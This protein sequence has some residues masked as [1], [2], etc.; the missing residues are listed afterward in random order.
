MAQLRLSFLGTF[1]VQLDERVITQ[2]ESDKVRALLVYLAEEHGKAHTRTALAGL[3]WPE[4]PES[5]ARN[6]LRQAFFKLRRAIGDQFFVATRRTIQW[7]VNGDFWLDTAVF[8]TDP[9]PHYGGHFLDQFFLKN[10]V[11]FEEWILIKREGYHRQAMTLLFDW[12]EQARLAGDLA[13]AIQLAGRQIELD[14][15]REEAHLQLMQILM[16]QGQR[17]EAIAQYKRCQRIL[18]DELGV[19][20]SATL[21]TFYQQLQRQ[22][23]RPWQSPLH[24]LPPQPTPFVGRRKEVEELATRLKTPNCRLVTI[25][26]A[27]GMGKTRLSVA[28]GEHC[29]AHFRDGV[30]FIPL[31]ALDW[32]G[33][34]VETAVHTLNI[35]LNGRDDPKEQL[36]QYLRHKNMLLIFDN[37]EHLLEGAELLQDIWQAAPEIR[38]LVTSRER[39]RFRSEWQFPLAGLPFPEGDAKAIADYDAVKLFVQSTRMTRPD[40]TLSVV[41]RPFIVQICQLM[42]GL[43]LGIELAAAWIENY[44]CREI[45]QQIQQSLDFVVSTWRDSPERHQSLR[46]VFHHSWQLLTIKEQRCLAQLGVLRGDFSL[47]AAQAVAQVDKAELGRLVDKSLLQSLKDNRYQFHETIRQ[48]ALEQL[49]EDTVVYDRYATFYLDLLQKH[50]QYLLTSTQKEAL[51]AIGLEIDHIRS[52]WQ[53]AVTQN[54]Q[55]AVQHATSPLAL[56]YE[57]RSWFREGEIVFREAIEQLAETAVVHILLL[58]HTTFLSRLGHNNEAKQQAHRALALIPSD[59]ISAE[60]SYAQAALGMI[61][62]NQGRFAQA[63]H[64]F[65]QSLHGYQQASDNNGLAKVAYSLGKICNMQGEFAEA[66]NFLQQGLEFVQGDSDPNLRAG[67]HNVLGITMAMSGSLSEARMHFSQSVTSYRETGYLYGLAYALLNLAQSELDLGSE[68]EQVAPSYDESK[69]I[70]QEI[71]DRAGEAFCQNCL[72][73]LAWHQQDYETA[74]QGYTHALS[75]RRELGDQDGIAVSLLGLGQVALAQEGLAE[76]EKYLRESVQLSV[77]MEAFPLVWHGLARWARLLMAKGEKET[78]VLIYGFLTQQKT[79]DGEVQKMVE[80]DLAILQE[81]NGIDWAMAVLQEG[82]TVTLSQITKNII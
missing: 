66:K 65:E 78:A 53:W 76:A 16:A 21:T 9:L 73:D 71:G 18:A 37:F 34:L 14:A 59:G 58:R 64:H 61:H 33:R 24:N 52:A 5:D 63:R 79:I 39:L 11:A 23:V 43:P 10:C 35:P 17:S 49:K 74:A 15:W 22:E 75:Q 20:P 42:A 45:V 7:N 40:F 28:V 62:S 46:A 51:A 31:A 50:G 77:G 32:H 25:L 6:N 13:E 29:L 72:A 47:A 81:G 68:P 44:S 12:A 38:L 2:F 48:Y 57:F 67:L 70:F 8:P 56:F 69:L 41:E 36:L 82:Q 54:W 80:E 27:G 19:A 60:K 30:F 4:L 3:L 1:Q 55:T 26:G